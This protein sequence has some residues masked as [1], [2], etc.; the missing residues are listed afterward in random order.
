MFAKTKKK[1]TPEI[2]LACYRKNDWEKLMK[3]IVD[4]KSMHDTWEEWNHEYMKAKKILEDK[5]F[6][7]HSIII[8]IDALNQYCVERGLKND[9]KTR[10]HYVSK[11]PLT[12]VKN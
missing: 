6:I 12:Q 8:D 4:R 10:S 1:M 9:G 11:L 7:V 2:K 5:G 3:S